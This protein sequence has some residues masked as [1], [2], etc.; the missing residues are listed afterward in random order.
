WRHAFGNVT[1]SSS[2]AFASSATTFSVTGVPIARDS[3]VVEIGL[4][5]S[6]GKNAK[7]G[8]SYS[9][10]YGSGYRDNAIQG[11]LLWRF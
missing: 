5:V 11:N 1:P 8:V 4:D 3:A 6:V 7:V 2:L 10:Q 9:G